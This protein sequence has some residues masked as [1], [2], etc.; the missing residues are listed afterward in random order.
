VDG[1]ARLMQAMIPD[2]L[3]VLPP[4]A[5]K[6]N[7]LK[8]L[9]KHVG[10]KAEHVLAM[11]DGENDID[12]VQ[13]AGIGVAVGNAFQGLKDIADHVVGTNDED[14]VAQA[15]EQFVLKK[16]LET[17]AEVAPAGEKKTES[18]EGAADA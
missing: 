17:A 11:G 6:G 4:N 14:G 12:M 18:S 8:V 9:L 1:Q 5:S 2:M 3:E 7:A 10:V 13:M 16:P 15:L